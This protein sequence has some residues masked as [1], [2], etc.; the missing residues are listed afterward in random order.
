MCI[1][2]PVYISRFTWILLLT[3]QVLRRVDGGWGK[4]RQ[5]V[6]LIFVFCF[7]FPSQKD[8]RYIFSNCPLPPSV[9]EHWLPVWFNT[10]YV[11]WIL[12]DLT[13]FP[14]QGYLNFYWWEKQSFSQ[15]TGFCFFFIA[16]SHSASFTRLMCL[17]WFSTDES[18]IASHSV[19]HYKLLLSYVSLTSEIS[20]IITFKVPPILSR[21]RFICWLMVVQATPSVVAAIQSEVMTCCS[22]VFFH[23]DTHEVKTSLLARLPSSSNT[24]FHV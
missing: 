12:E 3:T 21:H 24:R 17:K 11:S 8:F 10:Y 16:N 20:V 9:S 15:L 13:F 6:A 18:S 4:G 23:I 5:R 19:L 22:R 14:F 7:F 2:I 1:C